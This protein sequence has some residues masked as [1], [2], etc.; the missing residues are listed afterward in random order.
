MTC[1]SLIPASI[2]LG[3]ALAA[4]LGAF[5]KESA[6]P[7]VTQD[8]D[9]DAIVLVKVDGDRLLIDKIEHLSSALSRA[10]VEKFVSRLSPEG[11]P[12]DESTRIAFDAKAYQRVMSS[13]GSADSDGAIKHPRWPANPY[14]RMPDVGRA[15][16]PRGPRS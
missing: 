13:E 2:V 6:P 3:I 5:A 12:K 4:P 7:T 11:L 15:Q 16:N 1:R 9:Y 10:E 14:S 8:T